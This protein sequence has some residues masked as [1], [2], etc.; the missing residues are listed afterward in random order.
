MDQERHLERINHRLAALSRVNHAI[1]RAREDKEQLL[2]EACQIIHGELAYSFVWLGELL[3]ADEIETQAYKGSLNGQASH[4]ED[5]AIIEWAARIARSAARVQQRVIERLPIE[6]SS[7]RTGSEWVLAAFPTPLSY[8]E[9]I[10]PTL[11]LVV[12]TAAMQEIECEELQIL[13]E[14][15][16]DLALAVDSIAAEERSRRAEEAL[17][18]SEDRFRR[19]AEHSLVGIVLIQNDLY[20]YVNPAFVRMFGYDSPHEIIDRLGPLDL[21]A[22]ECR[23]IV[24][25]NV[26]KRVSGQVRAVQYQYRGKRKDG[27]AIDIEE[28]GARTI[29]AQRLAVIATV[30]DVTAREASRRRLEALSRAGLVLARAQTPEQALEKAA[31]QVAEI[32]PC[33]AVTIG[34]ID[35]QRLKVA[36]QITNGEIADTVGAR[37]QAGAT[38]ADLPII[39][40]IL[41]MRESVIVDLG[42]PFEPSGAGDGAVLAGPAAPLWPHTATGV[43]LIVRGEL[44][45]FIVAEA[46]ADRPLANEDAQHLRLFADHVAATYQHLHLISHLEQER[47]RLR[48]LNQLSHTLSETLLLQ[49]V[50]ERAVHQT[51]RALEADICLLYLW[52][53]TSET[54]VAVAAEG[55]RAAA[56]SRLNAELRNNPGIPW[57]DW[58]TPGHSDC[59]LLKAPRSRQWTSVV[60]LDP[61]C[62]ATFD[63]PLEARGETIGFISFSRHGRRFTPADTAL[64]STLS[65]PIALAIQNVRFYE[66]ISHQAELTSEALRRQEELDQMKD[67]L[68]QNIS[69]EL[70]TPLA[71]VM[72]YAEMLDTGQ[73]GPVLIAE[74]SD[75]IGV[76]ARRSRMLRSLVEDISLLWNVDRTVETREFVDLCKTVEMAIREFA[77]QAQERNLELS[78][79]WP[80]HPVV[81]TGVPI[82]IRRV[83][84][85]LLGNSLKF[86][87]SGGQIDVRLWIEEHSACLSVTDDGIG[88]PDD[89][90]SRIFERFYQVDGSAKRRY[91]GTGLGLALVKAIVESHNGTIQA[92]SPV[93]EDAERPGTQ[94]TIRLPLAST[95]AVDY[96]VERRG[97]AR[98]AEAGSVS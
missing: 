63:Q 94:I 10:S 57:T 77:S 28:H 91:G 72:G 92:I 97:A 49:E 11:V 81:V 39:Q 9:L 26:A 74:Q 58:M 65:V 73:L 37:I 48:I 17:R 15:N 36:A 3:Q 40:R 96:G 21:T 34:L 52:D 83:L 27:T 19:L 29:H 22:P 32:W 70:R 18:I 43:P 24:A 14:L 68:I 13:Q 46:T 67:E 98:R 84:D 62:T 78:G 23:E 20:R 35:Q 50:V 42:R 69:H 85:N 16:G 53:A 2:L 90:L 4:G 45:G 6:P 80:E 79:E 89:K 54:L 56:F 38:V 44:I 59:T 55:L 12:G 82:H 7:A 66:W 30:M 60:G 86:T 95:P 93:R 61:A 75:A 64:I 88:V 87:R 33:A 51:S 5:E 8:S 31:E 1:L 76:I 41:E 71:L 25:E 47:N